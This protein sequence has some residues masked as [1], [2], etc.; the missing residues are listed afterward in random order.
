MVVIQTFDVPPRLEGWLSRFLT[1]AAPGLF[2]G[3]INAK[4]REELWR[5]VEQ[6]LGEGSAVMAWPGGKDPDVSLAYLGTSRRRPFDAEG[7]VL[8]CFDKGELRRSGEDDDEEEE[9]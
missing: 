8:A 3:R 2:V 6:D 1:E 9:E 5:R 7:F 4:V